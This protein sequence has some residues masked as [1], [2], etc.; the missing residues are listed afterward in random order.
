MSYTSHKSYNYDTLTKLQKQIG[1]LAFQCEE[2]P[3]ALKV[4]GDLILETNWNDLE[5]TCILTRHRI[6]SPEL[7]ERDGFLKTVAHAEVPTKEWARCVAGLFFFSGWP[8]ALSG[9]PVAQRTEIRRRRTENVVS[10]P[11]V[12]VPPGTVVITGIRTAVTARFI[13]IIASAHSGRLMVIS[14]NVRL[15]PLEALDRNVSVHPLIMRGGPS[16]PMDQV[17]GMR[18]DLPLLAESELV[19][20]V[21][22]TSKASIVLEAVAIVELEEPSEV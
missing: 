20:E 7:I 8:V 10:F 17:M 13:R 22:N 19:L 12:D 4:L 3:D 6:P 15:N 5:L 21:A 11:R 1:D 14:F 18:W 9:W 16:Y 2:D